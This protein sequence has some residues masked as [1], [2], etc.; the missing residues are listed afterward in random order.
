M[1]WSEE[2]ICVSFVLLESM[3][4]G[5]GDALLA[6][7]YSVSTER[8]KCIGERSEPIIVLVKALVHLRD[9]VTHILGRACLWNCRKESLELRKIEDVLQCVLFNGEE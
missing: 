5:N 4:D 1:R 6:P 9:Q 2:W 8:N 3:N 7:C